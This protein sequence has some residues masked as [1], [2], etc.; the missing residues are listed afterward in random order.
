MVS[1]EVLEKRLRKSGIMLIILGF[2][3][4][5]MGIFTYMWYLS[6]D[7]G[8][9]HIIFQSGVQEE[10]FNI[11]II[12]RVIPIVIIGAGVSLIITGGMFYEIGSDL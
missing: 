5:A 3:L 8:K 2:V 11:T 1:I 4:I 7:S 12:S 10:L 6:I 9:L